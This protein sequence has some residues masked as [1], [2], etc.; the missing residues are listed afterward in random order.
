MVQSRQSR[1]AARAAAAAAALL[2]VPALAAGASAS[3]PGAGGNARPPAAAAPAAP[4]VDD[5]A[6]PAA[7]R[8]EIE[9]NWVR[10]FD[11]RTS[12]EERAGVLEYGDLMEPLLAGLA[13]IPNADKSS[14]K[15][16]AVAF[17]SPTEATVTYDV[18]VAGT[19]E[20]SDSKGIAV[21]DDGVWKVSLKSLCGLI[22]LSGNTAPPLC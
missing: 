8:A 15:V 22:E 13:K 2:L 19:P 6:D 10:F 11:A 5:P 14:A 12:T 1:A 7:A 3:G 21:L 4:A 17:T 9:R 16:K 20:L 18:L